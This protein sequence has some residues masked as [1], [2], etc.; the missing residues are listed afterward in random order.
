MSGHRVRRR[1]FTPMPSAAPLPPRTSITFRRCGD[2]D[3]SFLR[4]LYGTTRDEELRV[5]PWTDEQKRQFLD[6]QFTAQKAHYEQYYPDCEFLV[7]ELDRTPVGRLYI[8]RGDDIR[9][10]DIALLPELRGRGIGRMLMEEILEEGRVTGKRVTIHVE[11]DNP[12]RRLYDRLGFR[13]VDTNGV[14]HLL[15]WAAD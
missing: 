1:S 3:L 11:H 10:T 6:M 12:A 15:E 4:H 14:Y 8:D 13:H 9:I 2:A 7:I 5:V